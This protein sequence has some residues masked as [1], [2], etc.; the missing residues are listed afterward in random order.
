MKKLFGITEC[1]EIEVINREQILSEIV[2]WIQSV[3][4]DIWLDP[5]L[6][7]EVEIINENLDEDL[8]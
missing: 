8:K 4:P 7:V 1:I 5:T 6:E 3:E 2:Q